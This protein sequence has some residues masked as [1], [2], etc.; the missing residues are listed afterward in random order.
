MS[1]IDGNLVVDK[2][3]FT[4]RDE[5]TSGCVTNP[6]EREIGLSGFATQIRPS[7]FTGSY[8]MAT[9]EHREP[10]ESRGSR[11]AGCPV[12][13]GVFSRRQTCRGKS[14]APRSLDGRV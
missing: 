2:F 4:G 12:K 5:N 1:F 3:Q 11:T 7:S 6:K 13:A 8:G 9:A 14:Q 10:R